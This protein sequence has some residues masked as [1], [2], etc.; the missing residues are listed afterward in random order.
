MNTLQQLNSFG[1]TE[2]DVSDLRPAGVIF[3]RLLP[4][5]PTDITDNI[6]TTTLTI[7]PTINIDEVINYQTA[8]VRYRVEI[9]TGGPTPLTGS[10]VAF[11]TLPAGVSLSTVGT[12]YTLS[13]IN[14]KAVWD[15][16]KTFTWTLPANYASFPLWF[17]EVSI[18][19]YDG[20]LE[21]ERVVD[22]EVY[23]DDY[24]YVSEME[25]NA[26]V[27][28][29]NF[30][31][32]FA[33]ANISGSASTL[34]VNTKIKS[35]EASI[36]DSFTLYCDPVVGQV[37]EPM[38]LTSTMNV[39][40]SE[41]PKL[42][43]FNNQ[44]NQ[45]IFPAIE[46][47]GDGTDTY[48]FQINIGTSVGQVGTS[49]SASD[50][51]VLTGTK[52]SINSQLNNIYYYP[53]VNKTT[54]SLITVTQLKNGVQQW[55][56]NI[57]ITY[58]GAGAISSA[59]YTFN[60]SSS[61]T[62]TVEQFKYGL[63]DFLI[64]GAGGAGAQANYQGSDPTYSPSGGPGGGGGAV[65]YY[66]NNSI[67]GGGYTV[68]V[69]AGGSGNGGN[70]QFASYTAN[71]GSAGFTTNYSVTPATGRGG[72]SGNGNAGS[73]DRNI[74]AEFRFNGGGGGG[75][76][77]PA[78]GSTADP[79][80]TGELLG[81]PGGAGVANTISGTGVTYGAGG[82]GRGPNGLQFTVLTT[83]GSGGPGGNHLSNFNLN[84]KNGIVII[85]VH[86]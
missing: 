54:N 8:N 76:G 16:I 48:G 72:S 63:M 66:T 58:A 79:G 52:S 61:W 23:D 62:P 82:P 9:R 55:Q 5:G 39:L 45:L 29:G 22:W 41:Y 10:S 78:S 2:L 1:Q 19:Y 37:P 84:G 44:A 6:A 80:S 77:A 67:S 32:R 12:Q 46:D 56:R 51:F 68:T 18:L 27:S 49:T 57:I 50:V 21:E 34:T 33:S 36:N 31:T 38:Q 40:A 13:G 7:N 25:S 69:G 71:G 42:T 17:L 59:T 4:L 83:P 30:R 26:S 24:Y 65:L 15:A 20:K 47:F 3:D 28:V 14:S 85:R 81:S 74:I 86:P 35:L 11:G 53:T 64:V 73:F 70:S 75:A 43:Y 60:S